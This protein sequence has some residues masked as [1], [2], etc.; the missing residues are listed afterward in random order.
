MYSFR[1]II[2][3]SGSGD[4]E[5][6][7]LELCSEEERINKASLVDLEAEFF[8]IYF[9]IIYDLRGVNSFHIV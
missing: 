9:P 1:K 4:E 5:K 2:N 6:I 7:I 3:L 8:Y